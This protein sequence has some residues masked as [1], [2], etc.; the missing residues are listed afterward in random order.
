MI[1]PSQRFTRSSISD[2][3]WMWGLFCA[4]SVIAIAV[5][6]LILNGCGGSPYT[7]EDTTTNTVA[8]RAERM[9]LEVCSSDDASLCT[10]AFVRATSVQAFCANVRELIVH[11][12]DVPDGS[13]QCRPK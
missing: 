12:A 4:L 9:Q 5:A 7:P 6:G 11:K 13:A 8:A 3:A 1:W 10:P 2:S